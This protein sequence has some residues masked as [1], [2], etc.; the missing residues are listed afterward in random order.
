M[1]FKD[2]LQAKKE[3]VMA[4]EKREKDYQ[5]IYELLAGN[6]P[7]IDSG[8]GKANLWTPEEQNQYKG[9]VGNSYGFKY[10]GS[11]QGY[12]TT[13]PTVTNTATTTNQWTWDTNSVT[14]NTIGNTSGTYYYPQNPINESNRTWSYEN[15]IPVANAPEPEQGSEL[16]SFQQS[17]ETFR[18]IYNIGYVKDRIEQFKMTLK[19]LNQYIGENEKQTIIELMLEYIKNNI[20]REQGNV[21]EEN[22]RRII[23]D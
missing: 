6:K 2:I 14:Y 23:L 3:E 21:F 18:Q 8:L 17:L 1:A 22:K 9:T 15:S 4:E 20:V 13:K 19:E 16:D 7:K 10:V 5:Q 12:L 11:G